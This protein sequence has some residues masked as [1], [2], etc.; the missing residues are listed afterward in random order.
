[1]RGWK[2]TSL[3]RKCPNLFL[4][5]AAGLVVL[6]FVLATGCAKEKVRTENPLRQHFQDFTRSL[7]PKTSR[8]LHGAVFAQADGDSYRDLILLTAPRENKRQIETLFNKDGKEFKGANRFIFTSDWSSGISFLAP[9]DFNGNG[10]DDLVVITGYERWGSARILVNN[11]KGYYYD[12]EKLTFPI[13]PRGIERV[14]VVDLDHDNDLDLLFTGTDVKAA[15]GSSHAYQAIVVLN[16]R[17]QGFQDATS[18]LMPHLPK[19]IKGTSIADFDGDGSQ[20]IFLVYENGQNRILFNNGLGKFTD[21]TSSALPVIM[22]ESVHADWA[23]FDMD[24]DNDLLVVNRKAEKS[25]S[26]SDKAGYFLENNGRGSFKRRWHEQLPS[27]S[28]RKVYLLDANGSGI[29]DILILSQDGSHFYTGR[30]A[31]DFVTDTNR[32]L[33]KALDLREMTFADI[34]RD[35]YLDLFA[36]TDGGKGRVWLNRFD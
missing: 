36:L 35:G 11:K 16:N 22:D 29:P 24:G 25:A 27:A 5:K 23:D 2:S 6:I 28:S 13:I 31:W 1:M 7:F 30:G 17:D 8:V 12:D 4:I 18:L 33:P 34:D 14:D 10:I 15:D 20:D 19:G 9:G 21:R 32:R 26:S 3:S